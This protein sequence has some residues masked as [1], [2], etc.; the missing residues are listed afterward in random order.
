MTGTSTSTVNLFEISEGLLKAHLH[1]F[2]NICKYM[3]VHCLANDA[4]KCNLVIMPKETD[5]NIYRLCVVFTID[6]SRTK[7]DGIN[8]DLTWQM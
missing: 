3:N 8:I 7:L 5:K 2:L 1:F 6:Q 4:N